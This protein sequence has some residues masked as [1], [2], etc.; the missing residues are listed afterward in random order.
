MKKFMVPEVEIVYFGQRDVIATSVPCTC[1]DC[2]ICDPGKNDCSC[3][4]FPASNM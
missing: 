2:T 4:E 3:Y 1:V